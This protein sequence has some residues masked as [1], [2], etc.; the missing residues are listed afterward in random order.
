MFS[1][2]AAFANSTFLLFV[3]AFLV[4][5]A[6]HRVYEPPHVHSDH[7]IWVAFLGLGVN[8]FGLHLFRGHLMA[9]W[10][11]RAYYSRSYVDSIVASGAHQSNMQAVVLH[12]FANT[13]SSLGVLFT[14]CVVHWKGWMVMDPLATLLIAVVITQSSWPLLKASGRVLLQSTPGALRH[15]L[16]K[17]MREAATLEGVLECHE[18]HFWAMAPG[19]Y[20]ATLCVRARSDANEQAILTEVH[21]MLSPFITHLTVQVEKDPPIDWFLT[22]R[23]ANVGAGGGHAGGGIGGGGIGAGVSL[24]STSSSSVSGAA[25]HHS[26]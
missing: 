2:L 21:R 24:S 11:S 9:M 20:V 25:S 5:E 17:I 23:E 4:T 12:V 1:V 26:H 22:K 19:V 16:Q 15:T 6:T 13:M 14:S 10:R 7:L 18:E 8:I 3:A